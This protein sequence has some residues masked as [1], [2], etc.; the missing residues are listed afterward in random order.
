L[1]KEKRTLTDPEVL[2]PSKKLE[3]KKETSSNQKV[4]K[5][6]FDIVFMK[7]LR[8]YRNDNFYY[9]PFGENDKYSILIYRDVFMRKGFYRISNI[10]ENIKNEKYNT[11]HRKSLNILNRPNFTDSMMESPELLDFLTEFFKHVQKNFKTP[12]EAARYTER[13]IPEFKNKE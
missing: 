6:D 3:K 9:I 10:Y 8:A 7:N 5:K 2:F 11:T 13:K 12:E 4:G 1:R